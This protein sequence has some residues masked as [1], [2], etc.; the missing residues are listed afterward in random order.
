MRGDHKDVEGLQVKGA[1]LP[2]HNFLLN[3]FSNINI[4]DQKLSFYFF[5]S[6]RNFICF[7]NNYI[8]G[9]FNI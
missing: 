7:Q 9:F 5:K 1:N 6:L 2:F 3:L 8:F 4:S